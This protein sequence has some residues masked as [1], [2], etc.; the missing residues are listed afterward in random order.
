M[1]SP[2]IH[3]HHHSWHQCMSNCS[4]KENMCIITKNIFYMQLHVTFSNNKL[5]INYLFNMKPDVTQQLASLGWCV[6]HDI[7]NVILIIGNLFILLNN[8]YTV[9]LL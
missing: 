7:S 3:R 1:L 6:T 2:A 8:T 5:A 9:V 4:A